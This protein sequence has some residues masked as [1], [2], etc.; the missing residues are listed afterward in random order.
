MV[1]AG[2]FR[3]EP[4]RAILDD[5]FSELPD[6]LP[7]ITHRDPVKPTGLYAATKVW[8]EALAYQYSAIHGLSCICLRIGWVVAENRPRPKYGRSVWCSH[9]DVCQ[10]IQKSLEAPD[11]LRFDIFYGFSNNRFR[12][13]NLEHAS[14]VLGYNPQ[15]S[16][17][18]YD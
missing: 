9:R 16:S 8:G 3:E 11:S 13:T 17:E 15:D 4:Y 7:R 10:L 6:P 14:E 2:Y 1:N 5:R 18:D 12:I